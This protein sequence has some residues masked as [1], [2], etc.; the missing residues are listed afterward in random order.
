MNRWL[1]AGIACLVLMGQQSIP[2]QIN[3]NAIPAVDVRKFGAKCDGSTNDNAAIQ[4][5]INSLNNGTGTVLIPA[6]QTCMIS[7]LTYG[8]GSTSQ[9][10]TVNGLVLS[11]TSTQGT[12]RFGQA[13]DN[14]ILKLVAGS[15]QTAITIQGPMQGYGI[16]NLTIDCNSNSGSTGL[17]VQSAQNGDSRDIVINNCITG[18]LSDAVATLPPGVTNADS[19]NNS[20]RNLFINM[21]ASG[22]AI[23]AKF[24]GNT[25]ANT[26]YDYTSNL[27]ISMVANTSGQQGLVLA[28][29]DSNQFY[30]THI[31]NCQGAGM[32]AMTFDYS[33]NSGG[34][35][36]SNNFFGIDPFCGGGAVSYN[37]VG[38]PSATQAP[39]WIYGL[40]Q[41]NGAVSNPTIPGLWFGDATSWNTYTPSL[42]C[43][44]GTLTTAAAQGSY[45]LVGRTVKV[46]INVIITTNG[47]CA[48]T[49]RVSLPVNARNTGGNA[50]GSVFSMYNATT[51]VAGIG[52]LNLSFDVGK[53]IMNTTTGTY[54]GADATTL[55]ITGSYEAAF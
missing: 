52:L 28:G 37:N 41:T 16:Q 40:I 29:V 27:S 53:V 13:N 19:L 22:S 38:S 24:T 25:N 20:Y 44:A 11:S 32:I 21:P 46:T 48:G 39:N 45:Q 55:M 6:G 35:P 12:S 18:F 36:A 31:Y 4:A 15:N 34:W 49:L 17:H 51:G 42:S 54:P 8:N 3:T 1:L 50:P 26:D 47:T 7:G 9:T 33:I 10:S 23:G 2:P 30:D 5:A 14:T 43:A